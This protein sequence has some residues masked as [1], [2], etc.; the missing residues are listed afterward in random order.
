MA[1]VLRIKRRVSGAPG[2][3]T[4]LANAELA[5]N[6]VDHTLY[7]GEGTGGAGGTASV[8]R[9]IGGDG[10]VAN[11]QPLDAD[12]TAIA[13]L[14]GTNTIYYRS[15]TSAWTAVTIGANLTF[16]SGTLAAAAGI[17][18]A[19]SDSKVYGRI[20]TTWTDLGLLYQPLDADLT[21]LAAASA[22]G[23]IYYRS[24]ANTWA[25]VTIGSGI[26]FTAGTLAASGGGGNVSNSGTPTVNQ[27]AQWI[28]ANQIQGVNAASFSRSA[29]GLPTADVPWGSFKI[30]GLADPTNPQEAATKNYVDGVAQGIDAKASVR[31]ATTTN[32]AALSGLIAVDGIT[33]VAGDR[34]LVKDQTT[35]SANGIYVAASGAWTRATDADTWAELPSAYVFVEVGSTNAD[36]GYL[37]TV[38]AGGTIGTTAVTWVQFSGAGQI[39]AGNG[40]TKTGNQIDAV[41]TAGRISVAADSIDID[42]A[43]VGQA[44]ITTLGTIAT[45]TWNATIIG[46]AKGGTGVGTLTGYVKGAGTANLTASATI[47]NTDISGLGTMSTQAASAV[48]ITGG[49]IDGITF[50][51]GTF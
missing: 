14:G 48:A 35:Q 4:S 3:P 6:E 24:A 43:Y 40:L 45:G 13:A 27:I 17:T 16:S 19:T 18:D 26:T 46:V 31:M 38:D 44:T 25:T 21:S 29:W 2:A 41:G 7:Y 51:C 8:I 37:C 32:L 49:T 11:Y 9:A 50:D 23:A 15:G 5:Y 10:L 12:L 33:A 39:T 22:T 36:N 1:D 34:V 28:N 30:T 42:A 20:N 47:P